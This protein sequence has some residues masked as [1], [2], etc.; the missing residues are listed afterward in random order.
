[1]ALGRKS[2]FVFETE[3][4]YSIC[5]VTWK[6]HHISCLKRIPSL[7]CCEFSTDSE[8]VYQLLID[9][10][11]VGSDKLDLYCTLLSASASNKTNANVYC[12]VSCV[13]GDK[14]RTKLPAGRGSRKLV[15]RYY[16]ALL[17][18]IALEDDILT[19]NVTLEF[20]NV[21]T[22]EVSNTRDLKP[23]K[24]LNSS[25]TNLLANNSLTDVTLKVKEKEL[26]AHR[27]ILAATSPVFQ[28]MFQ[29]GY[30]EHEDNYVNIQDIDSDVFEVFLRFLYSGEVDK[31]DEMYLDLFAAADKYDVQPLREICL[32][33]MAKNIS[34]DNAVDILALADRYDVENIKLQ[35]QKFI[36]NNMAGVMK[37]DSWAALL[38][39][40][41]KIA[42]QT[43]QQR[44]S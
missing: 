31:L 24:T 38:G 2:E 28:A 22:V 11:Q 13:L 16:L 41:S 21:G 8:E 1:M 6:I 5:C 26:K 40:Y 7:N 32:Q 9:S 29:E 39:I 42:K 25:V 19:L 30:K 15:A 23:T 4:P 27:V 14:E 10:A 18:N 44:L 43:I 20:C 37:T 36:T 35:A 3:A 33:H 12:I 17:K 34:V